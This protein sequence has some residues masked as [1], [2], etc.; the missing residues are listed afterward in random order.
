MLVAICMP[1]EK[2]RWSLFTFGFL[3]DGNTFSMDSSTLR[4]FFQRATLSCSPAAIMP[5][6]RRLRAIHPNCF[7]LKPDISLPPPMNV[8]AT[9]ESSKIEPCDKDGTW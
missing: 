6:L 2:D 7:F 5:V 1:C 9:A 8:V 3:A 4:I